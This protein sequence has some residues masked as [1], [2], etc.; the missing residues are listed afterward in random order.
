MS[1]LADVHPVLLSS[2]VLPTA[3]DLLMWESLGDAEKRAYLDSEI[4]EARRRGVSEKTIDD[5]WQDAQRIAVKP[6]AI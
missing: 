2:T 6:N 5:L 3:D 4:A 1:K